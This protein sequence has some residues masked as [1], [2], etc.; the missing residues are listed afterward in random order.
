MASTFRSTFLAAAVAVGALVA[1]SAVVPA[2][3]IAESH[4]KAAREAVTATKASEPFDAILFTAAQE[5]KKQLIQ[6]DPNL[7]DKIVEIV[8]TKTLEMAPRRGD[9]EKEIAT[10]FAKAFSEQE[11]TEIANFY[12]T[13]AGQ[14]FLSNNPIVVREMNGAVDIW[15]RGIARDLAQGV[16]QTLGQVAPTDAPLPAIAEESKQVPADASTD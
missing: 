4:L 6:K 16:A 9:L 14:K 11:L 15:Q 2:Q 7:S 10:V 1:T 8:D 3:E 12:K 5:L 13:P